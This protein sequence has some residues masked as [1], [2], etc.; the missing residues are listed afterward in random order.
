M[1]VSRRKLTLL[2]AVG[3]LALAV[4]GCGSSATPAKGAA[5]KHVNILI[6]YQDGPAYYPFAVARKM[7][8]FTAEGLSVTVQRTNGS[9]FVTQQILAGNADF[10]IANAPDDIVAYTK[11]PGITVP[12]CFRERLVYEIG[13]LAGSPIHSVSDLK[14]K[15]LGTTEIGSGEYTY[16]E[17][18]LR[19]VGLTPQKDVKLLP[20]GDGT[21]QTVHA[22]QTGQV[23]AY[24]SE[25]LE[26]ENMAAKDGM[27]FTDITPHYFLGVPGSCFVTTA[28]ALQDPTERKVFIGL[29][30]AFAKAS[31][32]G[33]ANPVA[34]TNMV[35]ADLP[36]TCL[37]KGDTQRQITWATSEAVPVGAGVPVGGID[38][39][40]WAEAAKVALQSGQ[41]TQSVDYT[42]IV[43]SPAARAARADILHFDIPQIQQAAKASRG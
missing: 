16:A 22:L 20:I 15:V 21:A 41:I 10:G 35:C 5:L 6:A 9:S 4:G 31:I 29:A 32:F 17:A 37:N 7:G 2:L 25:G 42:P 11:D 18:A 1:D 30:R 36:Q 24:I 33:I 19:D 43:D 39:A 38:E 12:T 26:F 14:G 27:Q 23:D 34:A 8:Y 28:K 13:V 3:V 40:G